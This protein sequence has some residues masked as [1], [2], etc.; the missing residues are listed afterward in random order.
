M[1]LYI[2]TR[3]SDNV[4]VFRYTAEEPIEWV[5][6]EFATHTHTAHAPP[7]P[8]PEPPAPVAARLV[9]RL[10]FRNRFTPAEKVAIELAGLDNPSAPIEQRALA[11]TLRV[12]Q[13]DVAV[14]QFIDLSREDTRMGV[15][16]MEG[17][18]L[19][20]AGRALEILDA[21]IQPT[22]AFNG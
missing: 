5:G 18:G 7:A 10:A 12:N 3:N 2:V 22:E 1:N 21:P 17:L 16:Q 19:L 14:A 4:V 15:M 13:Q 20:G 8:P 6:F 9:T 11:A